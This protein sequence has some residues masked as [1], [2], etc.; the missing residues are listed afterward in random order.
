M[1]QACQEAG[2]PLIGGETAQLPGIYLDGKSDVVG[3][4]VG[5][6]DKD[7]IISGKNIRPGDKIIGLPSLGLHTK[8][9]F[10]SQEGF[11]RIAEFQLAG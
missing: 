2:M 5:L 11:F 6:A 4:I 10:F 1:V 8:W 7:E 9:L 3:M